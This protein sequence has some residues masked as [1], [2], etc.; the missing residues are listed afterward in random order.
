MIYVITAMSVVIAK[1]PINVVE[2]IEKNPITRLSNEC[3][4]K[5][6]NKIR[7]KFTNTEQQLFV[8]SFYCFLNYQKTDFVIDL[9]N[10]WEWLGF[11]QKYNAKRVLEKNFTLDVDYKYSFRRVEEQKNTTRGGSNKE[12]ILL[13]IK[14]FKLLCLKTG[15]TKA[16]QI[17]EYYIN[18]EETLFETLVEK[19]CELKLQLEQ[20]DVQLSIAEEDKVLLREKTILEQ[21]TKNTQCVYYG[22]FDDTNDDEEIFIKFGN[23]NNLVE[24]VK[25]HKHNFTNFRLINAFKVDNKLHVENGMKSHEILSGMRRSMVVNG[26]NQ[27]ELLLHDISFEELDEIIRE[28]IESIEY[29]PENFAKLLEK[30]TK[31]KK[32]YAILLH[33]QNIS[34]NVLPTIESITS[35]RNI[36][37]APS[38]NILSQKTRRYEKLKDNLYHI[39]GKTFKSL[40]GTRE[41]VYNGFAYRTGGCLI[42]S[43]LTIGGPKMNKIV[44]VSKRIA[45]QI[46]NRLNKKKDVVM[47]SPLGE[48]QLF[49]ASP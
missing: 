49:M 4:N 34:N 30:N 46:E 7:D 14:T 42:K 24:R 25:T 9:D 8:A 28:I 41:E 22:I 2:L 31:L 39:D 36:L 10:I 18:L 32:D 21:F 43:D 44:S 29:S 48:N 47:I 11:N 1:P 40:N 27:T 12:K 45:S 19:S 33:K 5:L 3:N 35:L 16:D 38:D 23:S 20:K 15:T 17:H 13:N 37:S 6:L 26:I